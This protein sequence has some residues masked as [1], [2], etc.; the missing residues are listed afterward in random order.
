MSF[1]STHFLSR[2]PP[3]LTSLSHH[4]RALF[5][6]LLFIS[7]AAAVLTLSI[8]AFVCIGVHACVRVCVCV[9]VCVCVEGCGVVCPT[10][11][12]LSRVMCL[13]SGI[14]TLHTSYLWFHTHTLFT[15]DDL[16]LG[17]TH[18]SRVTRVN[19]SYF[20]TGEPEVHASET[21]FLPWEYARA[22]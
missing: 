22:H 13:G 14:S 16:F 10:C 3:L 20:R 9:C 4:H 8:Y 7:T 18:I 11:C 21:V 15:I 17:F 12:G 5:H 1:H 6:T 2:S 19:N